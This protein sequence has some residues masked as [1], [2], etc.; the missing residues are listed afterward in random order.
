MRRRVRCCGARDDSRAVA[1]ASIVIGPVD[2]GFAAS[3]ELSLVRDC[4]TK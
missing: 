3:A 2:T 4:H 1:N